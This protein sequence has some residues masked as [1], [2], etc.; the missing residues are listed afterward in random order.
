MSST[1][2]AAN[3]Q[4]SNILCWWLT[5]RRKKL[6]YGWSDIAEVVGSSPLEV[7]TWASGQSFPKPNQLLSLAS[8]LA[9]S[10]H[11]PGAEPD[12]DVSI[13]PYTFVIADNDL[14]IGKCIEVSEQHATVE[15][16]DTVADTEMR[17]V[18][19]DKLTAVR[20]TNQTR[21]YIY[22]LDVEQWAMGRIRRLR[23]GDRIIELPDQEVT[24]VD[25]Q[26]LYVRWARPVKDPT[27]TLQQKSQETVF[28]RNQRLPFVR[29]LVEQRAAS[30]GASGLLSSNIHLYP[31]QAEVV[32]RVL[33]DPIQRYL[34]ADEV[35][36]GKT[37]E[38]GV[39]LRQH[40]ID[41]GGGTVRVFA[42]SVLCEQW[43]QELDEKFDL[44]SLRGS[45]SVHPL[46]G[47][48]KWTEEPSPDFV[49]IDE[50]H[51]VVGGAFQDEKET[52]FRSLAKWV[53]DAD[54]LLL[55][56]ATP[57]HR[58]EKE[59]LAMLHLLDPALYDLDELEEFRL[60]VKKRSEVGGMLRDF[61]EGEDA[62]LLGMALEDL[63]GAFP[64]DE[65]LLEEAEALET[66]INADPVDED[67]RDQAIR[68]IRIHIKERYR[69]HH[70]MLRSRRTDADSEI[71]TERRSPSFPEYGM[72]PREE[73]VHELLD[74]WRLSALQAFET[75]ED[76]EWAYVW[77]FRVLIQVAMSDLPLLYEVVQLRLHGEAS[78]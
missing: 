12:P 59:F 3:S 77:L 42:P 15:Y 1:G 57:A 52:R 56:S 71:D 60:R 33:E 2:S 20:L 70:R 17:T 63:R 44:W 35:G 7:Q 61:V 43:R 18:P 65:R 72:D 73:E 46:E 31:H 26:H 64:D 11:P 68:T 24:N 23:G 6:E 45:V 74:Q 49:V 16:F 37:I 8:L 54:Q 36:L 51:K 4:V 75:D 47:I 5:E 14:G 58:H 39:I 67:A 76:Q 22:D 62:F 53:H 13:T 32:R 27:E 40:L 10:D 28:F 38:A 29:A 41:H 19:I 69:L 34:L 48:H 55:L 50:A 9:D 78:S 30:R 66:A 25:N 21:C